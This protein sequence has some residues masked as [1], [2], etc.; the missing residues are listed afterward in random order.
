MQQ[1]VSGPNLHAE[2]LNTFQVVFSFS[3]NFKVFFLGNIYW[4][5]HGFNLIEVARLNGSFRY[6]IISQGL[7]QPRSIAVHPEKG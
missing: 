5:D 2:D 3:S 4:T 7:D 6:V 1:L